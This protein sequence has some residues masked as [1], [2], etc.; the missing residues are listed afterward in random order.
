MIESHL[1]ILQIVVPLTA[2]PLCVLLRHKTVVWVF[3]TIVSWTTLAIAIT[4][5]M[6]VLDQGTLSYALG[7][8]PAPWGIEI[9]IDIVNAYILLLVAIIGAVVLLYAPSSVAEEIPGDSHHLFYS[10]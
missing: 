3:A 8:W 6:R 10:A 9:R 7:S 2:A 1:P 5:L 4:L